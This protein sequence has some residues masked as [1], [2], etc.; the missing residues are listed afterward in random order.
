VLDEIDG[1]RWRAIFTTGCERRSPNVR[2]GLH[3]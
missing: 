2:R 3:E 1:L